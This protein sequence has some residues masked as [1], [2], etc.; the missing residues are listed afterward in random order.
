MEGMWS[1]WC[2]CLCVCTAFDVVFY[3]FVLVDQCVEKALDMLNPFP[4]V[5]R[6]S[7]HS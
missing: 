6:V 4:L 1:E 3:R 5:V 7:F 2:V